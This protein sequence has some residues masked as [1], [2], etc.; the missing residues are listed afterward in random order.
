MNFKNVFFNFN[1]HLI[2][3]YFITKQSKS[4]QRSFVSSK[5]QHLSLCVYFSVWSFAMPEF[6]VFQLVTSKLL[7]WIFEIHRALVWEEILFAFANFLSILVKTWMLTR[8]NRDLKLWIWLNLLME[9][10]QIL[11]SVFKQSLNEPLLMATPRGNHSSD[12]DLFD[13]QRQLIESSSDQ[14]MTWWSHHIQ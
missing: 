13:G 4:Y 7:N 1:F 12:L 2:G 9:V 11:L 10:F 3:T 8:R 14:L 5:I 6:F